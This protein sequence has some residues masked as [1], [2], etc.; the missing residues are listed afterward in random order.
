MNRLFTNV[1]VF[2][3]AMGLTTGLA[4]DT[5]RALGPSGV[6]VDCK[7]NLAI[8][9]S[10]SN[11]HGES[12]AEAKQQAIIIWGQAVTKTHGAHY[13]NFWHAKQTLAGYRHCSASS[14]K[15][16]YCGFASGQPCRRMLAISE[17]P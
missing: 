14:G 4:V 5:Y 6:V 8:D 10:D 13:A 7:P 11:F 9:L 15:T 1:P 16:S 17:P 2:F 12:P 3:V